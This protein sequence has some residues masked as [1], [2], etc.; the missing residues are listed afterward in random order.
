MKADGIFEVQGLAHLNATRDKGYIAQVA[1]FTK[2][3]RHHALIKIGAIIYG[4]DSSHQYDIRERS[5][6]HRAAW[7]RLSGMTNKALNEAAKVFEEERRKAVMA[8]NVNY[9]RKQAAKLGYRLV[10][11]SSEI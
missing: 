2:R 5:K 7:C 10:R 1:K 11:D 4:T 6:E 8:D 9:L 3:G